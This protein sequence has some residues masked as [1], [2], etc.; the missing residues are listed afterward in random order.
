M[1]EQKIIISR[2][3]DPKLP[4]IVYPS[5][6]LLAGIVFESEFATLDEAYEDATQQAIFAEQQTAIFPEIGTGEMTWESSN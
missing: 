3:D 6:S 5:G 2:T 4:Y 1:S